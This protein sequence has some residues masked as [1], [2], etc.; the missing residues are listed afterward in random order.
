MLTQG[1]CMGPRIHE[2]LK[3]LEQQ[4]IEGIKKSGEDVTNGGNRVKLSGTASFH[5]TRGDQNL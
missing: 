3:G 4:V 2:Q 1:R 5:S